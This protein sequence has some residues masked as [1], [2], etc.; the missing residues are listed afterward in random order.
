MNMLT[1]EDENK[2][3]QY[4][5]GMDG[6]TKFKLDS[7][8]NVLKVLVLE[9]GAKRSELELLDAKI[10][11][12]EVAIDCKRKLLFVFQALPE[13]LIKDI[14]GRLKIGEL[15]AFK[16][17]NKYF[18]N[19]L[20]EDYTAMQDETFRKLNH[21]AFY[22]NREHMVSVQQKYSFHV[23]NPL[24]GNEH[25]RCLQNHSSKVIKFVPKTSEDKI[26]F[27]EALTS[28]SLVPKEPALPISQS[29]P[30]KNKERDDSSKRGNNHNKTKF[31]HND[32]KT[33]KTHCDICKK[34]G[35]IAAK[36]WF[37]DDNKKKYCNMCK[38][39]GHVTNKCWFNDKNK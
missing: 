17:T 31:A 33:T 12:M 16:L 32:K 5:V 11:A 37:N 9:R 13:D 29:N 10:E 15:L 38:K 22:H 7:Y 27:M 21:G 1:Q 25:R 34:H 36:C 28:K 8:E 19:F 39:P 3:Y 30:F 24:G 20:K 6:D 4:T 14:T 18:S 23:F 35:H 26:S 2:S